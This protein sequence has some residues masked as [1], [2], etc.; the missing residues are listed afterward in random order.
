MFST[1]VCAYDTGSYYVY[2]YY[3]AVW[4]VASKYIYIR[5]NEWMMTVLMSYL[6]CNS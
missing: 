6:P 1:V 4:C 2:V 5:Q 3:S